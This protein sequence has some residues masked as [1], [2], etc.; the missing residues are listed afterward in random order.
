MMK[1]KKENS[2]IC[3]V[4]FFGVIWGLNLGFF[5][6]QSFGQTLI[7]ALAKSYTSNPTLEAARAQLR[8]TDEKVPQALSGWR[9]TLTGNASYGHEQEYTD[10]NQPL[11]NAVEDERQPRDA[12]LDFTQPIFRGFRTVSSTEQ[13][14][15]LVFAAR[16]RLFAVE[17]DVLLRSI[18]AY[19]DVVRDQSV[20]ELNTNNEAVLKRQLEATQERFQVGE[21]TRTDVAQAE[22]RLAR[23]TAQRIASQGDLSSSRAIYK[24]VVG[25]MPGTLKTPP[26]PTNLPTSMDEVVRSAFYNPN[27]K[28]AEFSEKAARNQVDVA[29]GEM[30]PSVSLRGS[31]GV[32]KDVG[33]DDVYNRDGI[34]KAQVT[35]PL[36]QAGNVDARVREAKQSVSQRRQEIDEERRRAEQGAARSW[37]AWQTSQAQLVSLESQIRS[38][39]LALE[40]VKQESMVGTRTILDVLDAEQELLDAKVAYV[41]AERDRLVAAYSI[42][43]A[44]GHLTARDLQLP[45]QYYNYEEHYDKVKNKF[46]GVGESIDP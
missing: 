33:R 9:P 27:V 17:Q 35:I 32:S 31:I 13:A 45:V 43:A 19:V 3:F 16:A 15:N 46:F 14:D 29:F 38:A 7:D 26:L 6:S 30:L 1:Q 20:L 44:T 36:Y 2:W 10:T 24:E 39:E 25:D 18:T 40:G 4:V 23:S 5:I 21:I 28:E 22:A 12:T 41:T 42:F 34:I 37:L 11:I 8:A